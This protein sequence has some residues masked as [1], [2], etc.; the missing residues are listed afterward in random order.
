[1]N[2]PY[3]EH[4]LSAEEIKTVWSSYTSSLR[5]TY[6]GPAR[7]PQP[8]PGC[9]MVCGSAREA[10]AHCRI[11]RGLAGEALLAHVLSRMPGE[12][13]KGLGSRHNR[14]ESLQGA[15]RAILQTRLS[16]AARRQAK[17]YR[18]FLDRAADKLSRPA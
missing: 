13:A 14:L 9:G 16:P 3:C 18:G 17:W 11:P 15:V 6:A 2:C 12:L 10:W 8:C 1:M 4:E 7:Q 5:Q